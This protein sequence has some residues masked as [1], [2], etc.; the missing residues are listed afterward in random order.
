[1][2]TYDS[3]YSG[4]KKRISKKGEGGVDY[5]RRAVASLS[6]E[7]IQRMMNDNSAGVFKKG[8]DVTG[9]GIFN[10]IQAKMEISQPQDAA[11]IQADK[12]A[13]GVIQGDPKIAK[14]ALT[15]NA[16]SGINAKSEGSTMQ[17]T[18]A[19]DSQLQSTKGQGQKLDNN[20]KS[21]LEQH[22]GTDLNSVNI[23]TNSNASEMSENINA[24][25]FTHG[26]DI[27]F[28]QGQYNV[29]STEGKS[30]L[31]HEVAHTVQQGE[32]KV[33][34]KIQREEDDETDDDRYFNIRKKL[35]KPA[36]RNALKTVNEENVKFLIGSKVGI[37]ILDD[38]GI[39]I[40]KTKPKMTIL[41]ASSLAYNFGMLKERNE[42]I[43]SGAGGQRNILLES[44]SGVIDKEKFKTYVNTIAPSDAGEFAKLRQWIFENPDMPMTAYKLSKTLTKLLALRI[45]E[46]RETHSTPIR[47]DPN[48]LLSDDEENILLDKSKQSALKGKITAKAKEFFKVMI[49]AGLVDIGDKDKSKVEIPDQFL[50]AV[51]E[52]NESTGLAKSTPSKTAGLGYFMYDKNSKDYYDATGNVRSLPLY[53]RNDSTIYFPDND[54]LELRLSPYGFDKIANS[55]AKDDYAG[56]AG[57]YL[58]KE[59]TVVE[60][61]K[62]DTGLV[63]LRIEFSGKMKT[64]FTVN[65]TPYK[66]LIHPVL[67]G[68]KSI[69]VTIDASKDLPISSI[70]VSTGI[71]PAI[72]RDLDEIQVQISTTGKIE[73]TKKKPKKKIAFKPRPIPTA[74]AKDLYKDSSFRP[75]ADVMKNEKK[76]QEIDTLAALFLDTDIESII[77]GTKTIDQITKVTGG[78]VNPETKVPK[79]LANK[80]IYD[81]QEIL[82]GDLKNYYKQDNKIPNYNSP[83]KYFDSLRSTKATIEDGEKTF[84]EYSREYEKDEEL[85]EYLKAHEVKYPKNIWDKTDVTITNLDTGLVETS[86]VLNKERADY[87]KQPEGSRVVNIKSFTSPIGLQSNVKGEFYDEY[88]KFVKKG[89]ETD[90]AIQASGVMKGSIENLK[91][92]NNDLLSTLRASDFLRLLLMRKATKMNEANYKGITNWDKKLRDAFKDNK[93]YVTVTVDGETKAIVK[94]YLKDLP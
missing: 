51:G 33:Q 28:K 46:R 5:V 11:E 82:G 79:G 78:G 8:N 50:I 7:K 85:L 27:Y 68:G 17:T 10:K 37:H 4:K 34:P 19:F 76:M 42:Y 55:E 14:T 64:K 39:I 62:E 53:K 69:N 54:S 16:V 77:N 40:N 9:R 1:M 70:S 88:I 35:N 38:L 56:L 30:L 61:K 36:Y 29:T 80:S 45:I 57:E 23:H 31:A 81:L 13:E 24:K 47:Q 18:D 67:S 72:G 15:Q 25:A 90:L 12:V 48:R 83:E 32:G 26:Q 2:K 93:S 71:T 75:N 91:R 44:D 94:I 6:N 74:E 22:T 21:D 86:D 59:P 43:Y 66:E 41:E 84:D 89:S 73:L 52:M 20:T 63:L 49:D 58:N 92:S 87:A 3:G 65:A 60:I